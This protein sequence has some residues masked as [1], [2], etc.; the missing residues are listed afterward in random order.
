MKRIDPATVPGVFRR[1]G[2]KPAS[3]VFVG[4][5]AAGECCVLSVLYCD[6]R[7]CRDPKECLAEIRAMSDDESCACVGD[8]LAEAI[9]VS[10]GDDIYSPINYA[11]GLMLG[12]DDPEGRDVFG[13][14]DYSA[15]IRDGIA[16]R[17]AVA[18]AGLTV[19]ALSEGD[20]EDDDLDF[21]EDDFEDDD[22]EDYYQ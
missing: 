12:W 17:R 19:V 8:R 9:G 10:S 22:E 2:L 5:A 20:D 7:G 1:L 6:A 4:D 3:G 21:D 18:E 11:D 14:S 13:E 16:A 15:G